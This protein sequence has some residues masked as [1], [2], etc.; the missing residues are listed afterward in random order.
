MNNPRKVLDVIASDDSSES[1]K[2]DE[3]NE[4]NEPIPSALPVPRHIQ[5]DYSS[6]TAAVPQRVHQPHI[7][8]V[9]RRPLPITNRVSASEKKPPRRTQWRDRLS[10]TTAAGVKREFCCK[11]LRCFYFVDFNFYMENAKRLTTASTDRRRDVLKTYLGSDKKYRFDGKVVCVTFLKKAFHFSTVMIAEVASGKINRDYNSRSSRSSL[12]ASVQ[13]DNLASTSEGSTTIDS[14]VEPAIKKKKEAIMSFIQRLAE[15]CGD[16]MPHKPEVHLPFHQI[17]E[18]FP[19]FD[20]E[21]RKLYPTTDPVTSSYFR[22][23]WLDKCP[24]VKVTKSTRF[25]ICE[26]CD[27]IRSQL[28]DKVVNGES[29]AEVKERRSTHL[30]FVAKERMAYQR[31]KDRARLHGTEY[32]SV[33]ID[34]ADQSAFGLPHFTTH[35]KSQRGHAMK[36]KLVG[37]LE[38]RLINRLTLLTMTQEHQTGSNHVI[39]AL[40]RFLTRKRKEGPLPP[41]LFVQ[42]DNCSRENKNKYVLAYMELLVAY[43]VFDSVECG[44]L[45]VG[46]THEDVDQAFSTTSSRLR[47]TNAITLSDLHS[48]L[49]LSYGGQVH[50]QHMKR[51]ANFSGLCDQTNCLRRIDKVTQWRYFLF[52]S[53]NDPEQPREKRLKSIRSTS[54]YVKKN[55]DDVWENLYP[56][57]SK[58]L[59]AGILKSCPDIED[60]PSLKVKCPDG[61]ED[62]NKRIWSE[63]ER[64]NDADKLIDLHELRDFVFCARTDPFH[65]DLTDLVETEFKRRKDSQEDQ[66]GDNNSAVPRDPQSTTDECLASTSVPSAQN[67]INST[68]AVPRHNKYNY[69]IGSFVL[70]RSCSD[71]DDAT[72]PA[73]KTFWVAKVV[74]VLKA[75]GTSY[76]THLKV[77]WYDRDDSSSTTDP[78]M[79]KYSPCYQRPTNKRQKNASC[80]KTP[81]RDLQLPHYDEIDTDTILVSFPGLTR[82]RMIPLNTQK[83]MAT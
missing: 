51:V 9:R 60:T 4:D 74:A 69:Q 52:C 41:K 83:K 61:L 54:C 34:G 29:T 57:H 50:V 18:V 67:T 82:T 40:H 33:I 65:W 72:A 7:S 28:R 38:H 64:I 43:Q 55:C 22:R 75:D 31:K 19:I 8:R 45:P 63:D 59:R 48:V 3:D 20:R 46:H 14:E 35:P 26:V 42:L 70:V 62:V 49:R 36:V 27:S 25:S 73:I 21:F 66:R 16:A 71:G 1:W 32:C 13:S 44:F 78:F 81:R 10:T 80:S 76:A 12:I 23:I 68:P 56:A 15:D 37:L 5:E 79:A 47:V 24:N 58:A 77:H 11:T 39:E 30:S 6:P 2:D 53:E 17:Q